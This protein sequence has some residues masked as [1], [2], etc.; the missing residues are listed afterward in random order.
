MKL[1]QITSLS[2]IRNGKKY[3]V[4]NIIFYGL[5]GVQ[6]ILSKQEYMPIY[7]TNL[8]IPH[9]TGFCKLKIEENMKI[10]ISYFLVLFGF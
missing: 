8:A 9:F 10:T 6:L 5:I 1:R 3:K 7:F 4:L 2:N